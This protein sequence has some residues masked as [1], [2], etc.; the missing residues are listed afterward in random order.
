M[1]RT[2]NNGCLLGAMSIMCLAVVGV[3][4]GIGIG[5][6]AIGVMCMIVHESLRG[7]GETSNKSGNR[8]PSCRGR[9]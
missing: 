2:V 7:R 3:A 8:R 4:A 1:A 9:K 6:A 5:P